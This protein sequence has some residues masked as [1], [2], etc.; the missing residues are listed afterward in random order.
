MKDE[1]TPNKLKPSAAKPGFFQRILSKVDTAM[2]EKAEAQAKQSSCCSGD[3]K[4]KGGK[5]C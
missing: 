1:T 5:C 2:K 3:D 4:G